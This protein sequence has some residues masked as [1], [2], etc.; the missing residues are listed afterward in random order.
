[1][2]LACV[3]GPRDTHLPASKY[4]FAVLFSRLLQSSILSSV[5]EANMLLASFCPESRDIDPPGVPQECRLPQAPLV[6]E[7]LGWS[8]RPLLSTLS[9]GLLGRGAHVP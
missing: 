8:L 6:K 3:I 5:Q 4:L 9:I 2:T 7:E 1:M